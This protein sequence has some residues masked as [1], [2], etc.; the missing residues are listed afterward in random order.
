MRVLGVC[1]SCCSLKFNI[2]VEFE[3]LLIAGGDDAAAKGRVVRGNA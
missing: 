2:R 1:L 3:V